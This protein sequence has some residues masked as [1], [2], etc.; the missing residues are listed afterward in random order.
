MESDTET[1]LTEGWM[2]GQTDRQKEWMDGRTDT[3][4]GGWMDILTNTQSDRSTC[5]CKHFV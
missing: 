1:G 5:W 2:N 3:Q 4:K